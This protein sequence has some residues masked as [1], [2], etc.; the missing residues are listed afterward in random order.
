[1][2]IVLSIL[3]IFTL[4]MSWSQKSGWDI[5]RKADTLLEH[6]NTKRVPRLLKRASKA[7]YGFCG[8]AHMQAALEMECI[9]G[10]YYALQ[11]DTAEAL[12]H[13]LPYVYNNAFA[14]NEEVVDLAFEL[15]QESLGSQALYNSY[16]KALDSLAA[17]NGE[18]PYPSGPYVV[19]FMG[20]EIKYYNWSLSLEDGKNNAKAIRKAIEETYF[21]KLILALE[22]E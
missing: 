10:K 11:G 19:R 2:K 21:S 4:S 6:G 13:L 3:F 5:M 22:N 14:P 12:K 9:W 17:H 15:L 20:E 8:N 18:T 16:V 7:D 1:M